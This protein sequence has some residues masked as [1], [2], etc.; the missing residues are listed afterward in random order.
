VHRDGN[1]RMELTIAAPLRLGE[2]D[3][4]FMRV[5]VHMGKLARV[6][7]LETIT[8]FR[9]LTLRSIFSIGFQK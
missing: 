4:P 8:Y 7:A 5:D 2:H 6:S 9:R 3:R 1:G